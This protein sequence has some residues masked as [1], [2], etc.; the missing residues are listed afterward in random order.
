VLATEQAPILSGGWGTDHDR[1]PDAWA[2]G[3]RQPAAGGRLVP[4]LLA[5]GYEVRCMARDPGKLSGRPWSESL[6]NEVVCAEH[7]IA[8]YVPDPP[9]GLMSLDHSIALALRHT[10]EGDVSTRW[11]SAGSP[12]APSDPLPSDPSFHGAVFGGMLRNITTAAERA[13]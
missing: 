10:Q 2:R 3:D 9:E 6:R 8:E 12:G 13:G 5:A 11:S 1:Y 7:D 4:E